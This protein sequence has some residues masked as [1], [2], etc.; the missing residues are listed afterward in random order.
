[1][2]ALSGG[3]AGAEAKPGPGVEGRAAGGGFGA[4]A[5]EVQERNAQQE[6]Q[7]KSDADSQNQAFVRKATLYRLN[8]ESAQLA[9]SAANLEGENYKRIVDANKASGVLLDPDDPNLLSPLPL[10][11]DELSQK[12]ASKEIDPGAHLG[13][14]AGY[15]SVRQL[16][17]TMHN[18][19]T[20]QI[21]ND[22]SAKTDV[23]PEQWK[24]WASQGVR[25][26]PA[27]YA[28]KP[29]DSTVQISNSMRQSFANQAANHDQTDQRL[30]IM[31]SNLKGTPFA[32]Q[33]PTSVEWS[34]PGVQTAMS[35]FN[36]YVSND[37]DSS[38]DPY[39]ALQLM[40]ANPND[41]KY[42]AT[43]MQ[44]LGGHDLLLANHNAL[45]PIP[46]F[47]NVNE[48]IAFKVAHSDNPRMVQAANTAVTAFNKQDA[49][50]KLLDA[51]AEAQG[52]AN[53]ENAGGNGA[54]NSSLIRSNPAGGVNTGYLLSLPADQQQH[55]RAIAEG[56]EAA[57]NART[58]QGQ[59]QMEMVENY[60][61]DYDATKYPAYEAMRKDFVSGKTSQGLQALNTTL[62]HL[63]TIYSNASYLGTIPGVA[64]IARTSGNNAAISLHTAQSAVTDELGRAY[65]AGVVSQEERKEWQSQ[66]DGWTPVNVKE[67]A[68]SL[69][70][71]LDGKLSSYQLQ[72]QNGS[73][74]GA[75]QLP[76]L[77]STQAA[78]AYL[79]MTG[80]APNTSVGTTPSA[81]GVPA[82]SG[83]PIPAGAQVARVSGKVVGYK[84]PN[85]TYVSLTPVGGNQ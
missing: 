9:A 82:Q 74:S 13:A 23:S 72:L 59:A 51:Q 84:L 3:I 68:A 34:T 16:D 83:P 45:A 32:A 18:E 62:A 29:P 64:G 48:A 60:A 47:K 76:A 15:T 20:F 44:S 56:R 77:M 50:Q 10:T 40:A 41:R 67:S 39:R 53:V 14:M 1:M 78:A 58:K 4:G 25:G 79:H 46:E 8:M 38:A 33:V 37:I 73:P 75:V 21:I 57:P 85:G 2:E 22:P 6:A 43:V 11:K 54:G 24:Y 36:Q 26:I 66:V 17:G 19:P 35:K 61:P 42:V 49:Q 27:N 28:T 31:R 7:A 55:V 81:I 52:R 71:L 69:A 12:M 63:D 65:H 70:R 30:A 5:G 80:E